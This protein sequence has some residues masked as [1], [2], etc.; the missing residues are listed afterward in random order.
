MRDR[1]VF[2][3]AFYLNIELQI[4]QYQNIIVSLHHILSEAFR[5]QSRTRHKMEKGHL[6]MC[7]EDILKKW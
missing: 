1:K 5:R 7:Q 3:N 2:S 4:S 6:E